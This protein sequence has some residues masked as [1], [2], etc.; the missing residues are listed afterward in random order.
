VGAEG[1]LRRAAA[2]AI[3]ARGVDQKILGAVILATEVQAFVVSASSS[4]EGIPAPGA[5]FHGGFLSN[6]MLSSSLGSTWEPSKLNV[7]N[8]R[9]SRRQVKGSLSP[10]L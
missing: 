9:H 5:V 1:D 8:C 4:S 6:R 7:R 3:A 10:I 2:P